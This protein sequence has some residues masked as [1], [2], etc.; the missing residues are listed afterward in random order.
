MPSLQCLISAL[1]QAG[2]GDLLFRFASSVQSCY[3]EGGTLQTDIAV[4]W[5]AL[6]CFGHTGCALYRGVCAFPVYTAQ[7][8][9]CSIWSGPCIECGSSFWVLHK[10][11]DSVAPAC[12]VFPGLSGSGSQRLGRTLPG[13]GER[14]PSAAPARAAGRV[15]GAWFVLRSWPLAATLP[16]ADSQESI[17]AF[18]LQGSL[19]S[20]VLGNSF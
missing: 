14:F 15:P 16:V 19:I 18:K 6:P 3:R 10:G 5:R 20:G 1:T 12:C 4:V 8:P 11:A 7:A 13:C 9:G 2:R 17:V